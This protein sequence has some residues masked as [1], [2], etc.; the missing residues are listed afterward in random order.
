MDL[1]RIERLES[2]VESN[3]FWLKGTSMQ[4]VAAIVAFVLL[5]CFSAFALQNTG[6]A[7]VSF[8]FWSASVPKILLILGSYGLG[9]VSGW[10]FWAIF[11]QAM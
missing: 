1:A 8:L 7:D 3:R 10:G 5:L 11:R 6:H 4:K 9:I 2:F